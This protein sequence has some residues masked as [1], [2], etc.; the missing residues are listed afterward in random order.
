MNLTAVSI[1]V[2]GAATIFF[3]HRCCSSRTGA[4][5]RARVDRAV[6]G[7]KIAAASPDALPSIVRSRYATL[8]SADKLKRTIFRPLIYINQAFELLNLK[9]SPKSSVFVLSAFCLFTGWLVSAFTTISVISAVALTTPTIVLIFYACIAIAKRRLLAEFQRLLPDALD[10]V[11]RSVRA[12]LPVSEA[13]KMISAEVPNPVGA[14]F[15]EVG[16]NVSIGVSLTD[17][18]DQLASKFTIAEL[19]FFAISLAVQQETGGNL[20][21]ILSNLSKLMRK[22]VQ[23]R[24]KI[25]ALSSEARASALIIGSLPFIVGVVIF[26]LNRSY[27]EVLLFDDDGQILMACALASIA[28]GGAIMAKLIRFKI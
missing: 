17:A 23:V 8:K 20:A 9:I 27:I 14:A 11:V 22:R 5:S 26:A 19:R 24:K 21:E 15:R 18:L 13:I 7:M 12:G 2:G 6:N 4:I 28:T 25:R 1:A 10:L 3:V 16:S